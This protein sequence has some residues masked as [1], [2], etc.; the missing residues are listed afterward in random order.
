[1]EGKMPAQKRFKTDYP[2]VYFIMGTSIQGKPE[3][4]FM[5]R[6]RKDG[7][8][9]E[10]KA[11]RQFQDAMTPAKANAIRGE[12]LKGKQPSNKERREAKQ[13]EKEARQ[14]KQW[15]LTNLWEEY[16]ATRPYTHG[17]RSD[18]GRF[19]L[20]IRPTLGD[21]KFEEIAPLDIDRLR[22]SLLKTKSA[23]TVK[24]VIGI[25]KRL[26][27]FATNKRITKGLDFRPTAPKVSNLK[28]E[29]LTED[30]L[31]ALLKTIDE[32]SHPHAGPMMKMA[33]FTGMRRGELFKLRWDDVDF[34]RGFIHIREP[35]GGTDQIIPMN[36][37]AQAVLDSL[38]RG[39][40]YVFPGRKGKGLVDIH[41]A[42]KAI[43]VK[44]GLPADF[45][46]LHGLRHHFASSLA[47][48]GEADLYVI[49]KLL[50]HKSPVMTARYSHLRDAAL[51]KASAL[52]G[53]LVMQA[54][55]TEEKGNV[56]NLDVKRG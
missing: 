24:H 12:R 15:T 40:E 2:G 48:S 47:S 8:M 37:E 7:K 34:E 1:M 21:K 38:P 23:Q 54:T 19:K 36:D 26:S 46:P 13:R 11:G 29:F 4:I 31:R 51:K 49:Q 55:K 3:K 28:T 14:V 10:E 25:I 53:E 42:L 56:V 22:I 44:A 45:R 17:I 30:Q 39:T 16:K 50:T 9:I 32:D 52:A 27:N 6:Y 5:I 18:E 33:L 41:N 43:A 35:K 20:H